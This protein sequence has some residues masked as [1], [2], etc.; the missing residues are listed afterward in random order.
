MYS[1]NI[2]VKNLTMKDAPFW[3]NHIFDCDDVRFQNVHIVAPEGSLNTD[4]WDPDSSRNVVIEDSTYR[5]GDDCVAI[6]SG[7]DCFGIDYNKPSVNITIRNVTCEGY[8]NG[9]IAIGSEMSGGVEN[10][11]VSNITFQNIG[12]AL[13]IKPAKPRGGY[14]RNITFQD[15]KVI[16]TVNKQTIFV[17]ML[18]FSTNGGRN[19]SCRADW[20]PPALSTISD[21]TFLHLDGTQAIIEGNE[22]FHFQAFDESPIENVYLEDINFPKPKHGVAWNCTGVHGT[23]KNGTVT[24]WPPCEGFR[25]SNSSVSGDKVRVYAT[26]SDTYWHGAGLLVVLIL[27]IVLRRL[28]KN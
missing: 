8:R 27:S 2:R 16:G 4:G 25:V 22:A 13:I 10:V 28:L 23:Y 3:F 11:M 5:G 1:R 24:P 6:K 9:G 17:D 12:R 26:N 15:I 14:V 18:R 7:W 21:L 20:E 19:P